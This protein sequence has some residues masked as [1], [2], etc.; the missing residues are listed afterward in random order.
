LHSRLLPNGSHLFAASRPGPTLSPPTGKP[1]AGSC[2]PST[3][4]MV[5]VSR[6][7]GTRGVLRDGTPRFRLECRWRACKTPQLIL[8]AAF[9]RP[10]SRY[11]PLLDRPP[12]LRLWCADGTS[13]AQLTLPVM[14][15]HSQMVHGKMQGTCRI[16]WAS[17]R[18]GGH[19][20]TGVTPL[21]PRRCHGG[22]PSKGTV[23]PL[24]RH[25]QEVG[26]RGAETRRF[27]SVPRSDPGCRSSP[28]SVS[29]SSH[30]GS[31]NV[32][33]S[34]LQRGQLQAPLFQE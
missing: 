22:R 17:H 31:A 32:R 6:N 14:S 10:L 30:P 18:F 7:A 27:R 9:S 26:D 19:R 20:A 11:L 23:A 4:T 29:F 24:H 25:T 2:W 1:T 12:V 3:K 21:S 33:F 15:L 28:G 8:L 5:L 34:P 16:R 13:S